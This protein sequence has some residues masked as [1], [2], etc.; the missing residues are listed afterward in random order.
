MGNGCLVGG[1][2]FHRDCLMETDANW[3]CGCAFII[4]CLLGAHGCSTPARVPIADLTAEA[5]RPLVRTVQ[6]GETLYVL[7][8]EAGIDYRVIARANGLKHPYRVVPGQR[9]RIATP[10]DQ[11]HGAPRPRKVIVSSVPPKSFIGTRLKPDKGT[12]ESD[13]PPANAEKTQRTWLWPAQGKVLRRFTSHQESNGIEIGG[14]EGVSVGSFNINKLRYHK[15]I[16]MTDADVDGS[17]I[18]TLLLTFLYRKM[19][20][21]LIGGYVYIAQPPLYKLTKGKKI[22]YAYT[23]VE[24][25][26][27]LAEIKT[28]GSKVDI[29]R[30]KGLGEMNADQLWDTTMDPSS[31]TL[32]RVTI[33]DAVEA[34][35]LFF[36]LMGEEVEGRR[37]FIETNAKFVVNLDV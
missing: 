21:L 35:R 2:L 25:D 27:V 19:S 10:V 26:L 6:P 34:N 37:E 13:N 30:Y 5:S 7:A 15:I 36:K 18:R 16:I 32:L 12:N 33:D 23:D 28:D 9:I 22:R 24:K 14:K 20:E 17:H 8:W 3:R 4:G 11:T 29:S 1:Y 31:R